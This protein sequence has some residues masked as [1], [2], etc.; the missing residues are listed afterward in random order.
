VLGESLAADK[1]LQDEN[2]V[3]FLTYR[4]VMGTIPEDARDL[5]AWRRSQRAAYAELTL[6]PVWVGDPSPV[7]PD[8]PDASPARVV[9]GVA[10]SPGRVVGRAR[11]IID[12]GDCDQPVSAD[13]VLVTRTTDPSWV[14]MILTA[15]GLAIDI[16]GPMS[17]GAIVA[18][19]LGIPCVISTRD[20]T[21]RIRDGTLVELDGDAGVVRLLD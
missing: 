16:G 6:P 21:T 9:R 11:V 1:T 2:D 7:T 4:E 20:G 18:R 8:A 10:V 15:G 5:V 14:S 13:E 17:H 3:F 12:A 19:E